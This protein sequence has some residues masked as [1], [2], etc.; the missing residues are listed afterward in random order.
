MVTGHWSTRSHKEAGRYGDARIAAS[1]G[2]AAEIGGRE[3]RPFTWVPPAASW[4][5]R[6]E[7]AY[8]HLCSNETIGGVEFTDWPDLA[9]LGAPDVPLVV[10]ASS[11]SCRV[12]WTS[13][14]PACCLPARRKTPVRLV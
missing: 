7:A 14:A 10:D 11:H 3:Q 8:L 5:V 4:Q 2:Q 9:E 12:R 6:P 1:S 13:P